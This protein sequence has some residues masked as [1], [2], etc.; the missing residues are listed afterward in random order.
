MPKSIQGITVA[1]FY[2]SYRTKLR[3]ELVIGE[4]GL[5]R[6]IREGSINRPAL[7]LT[8]FFKYFANKRIQVLG[9]AEMTYLKTVPTER[10]VEILHEMADRQVPC[11]ILTRNFNPSPAML[12]VA[13]ERNL[14]MFRTPLITMHLI[15]Q[16]TLCIDN[17]F[18][19][20]V[21]EHATTLDI[22]GVGV[23]LRGTSGVGK[24]ECALA[25]IERGHSLV[26]DDLTVIKLLDERELM[27]SSRPLNR[28]YMECRGI[29]I[30]NIADMF[31]VKS[32]RMEKRIDL[33]VSLIEWTPEVIEERTG[34]EENFYEI[35][36]MRIPHVILYV[37]PGRDMARLVEVA[38]LTQA[39]KKMGHDPAKDFNDRL[40]AFMTR[41]SAEQT[42]RTV[43]LDQLKDAQPEE[44]ENEPRS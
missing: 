2:E 20:S 11:L 32:I 9:A 4:N 7:A 25:L 17:E 40:I 28:G 1:H 29:G 3:L 37:R 39:L 26:A 6:L 21:T 42:E 10:Q 14:P 16:A 35:L 33:V 19:P 44:E 36:K 23:M 12:A 22:R 24:S 13:A 8:G 18:A 30:I 31:G 34:L 15:N 38:A 41:Q 27:A 43:R 5:H